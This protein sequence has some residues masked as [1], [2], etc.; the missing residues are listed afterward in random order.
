MPRT[1]G[2]TLAG[3]Q[4]L[5]A[6]PP[7]RLSFQPW[8]HRRNHEQAVAGAV[9]QAMPA[10]PGR[11]HALIKA[12]RYGAASGREPARQLEQCQRVSPGFGQDPLPDLLVDGHGTAER[13][14]AGRRGPGALDSEP[15]D[16]SKSWPGSRAA[17]VS[18]TPSLD[19]AS[20]EGERLRRGPVQPLAVVHT[21]TSDRCVA[22]PTAGS[23]RP[24]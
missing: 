18:S 2:A 7:R 12:P 17:N 8:M 9:T 1:P 6:E 4:L 22:A 21:Q 24:G 19:P 13:S 11:G 14:S 10:V 3:Q 5:P 15:G 20:G 16:S 23:G